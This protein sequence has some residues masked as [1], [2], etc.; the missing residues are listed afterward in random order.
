MTEARIVVT[1]LDDLGLAKQ[2][3]AQLVELRLAA[4]VNIVER[5]HSIYRWKGQME[6][7]DEVLMVIKTAAERIPTLKE[8][9][10][11]LHPYE[12]PEFIVLEVADGSQ[13]YLAWLLAESRDEA[14]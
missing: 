11:Q 1:T 4:C 5:V 13:Q 3:A 9:I 6:S 8:T 2:L 12:L 14:K 7:A 10:A